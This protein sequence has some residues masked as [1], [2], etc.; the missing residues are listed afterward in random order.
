MDRKIRFCGALL[1]HIWLSPCISRSC[2]SLHSKIESFYFQGRHDPDLLQSEK[3]ETSVVCVQVSKKR[4]EKK[5]DNFFTL[6]TRVVVLTILGVSGVIV[7][8]LLH[9][10]LCFSAE[11][12]GYYSA[13]RYLTSGIG[14]VL[15]IKLLGKCFNEVNIARI[16]IISLASALLVFGFA[17]KEWLVFLCE[18]LCSYKT[19]SKNYSKINIP[20]KSI[21]Y[22]VTLLWNLVKWPSLT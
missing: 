14:A 18:C 20:C 22:Q 11:K 6:S 7:L 10:P 9:S 4:G 21:T 17:R 13:F 1:V 15:G 2:D 3:R 8:F 5:P 16:G 19:Y 12:V